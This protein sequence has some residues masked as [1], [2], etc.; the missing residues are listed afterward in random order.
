MQMGKRLDQIL[1]FKKSKFYSMIPLS[2]QSYDKGIME[3]NK[4]IMEYDKGINLGIF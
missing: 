4:G 3:Y 2:K 1:S